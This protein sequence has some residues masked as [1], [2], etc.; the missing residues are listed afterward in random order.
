M[1][2]QLAKSL[3]ARR[4]V[5]LVQKPDYASIY[6]QLGVDSAV[7]PRLICADRILSFIRSES[8]STIATIEEGKAEVL[9]LE[10]GAGS[11]LIGKAL[12]DAA[13]PRGCVVAA[14]TRDDDGAVIPRGH[15][16][17]RAQDQLVL[18]VLHDVVDTVLELVGIERE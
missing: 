4:T 5:A 18:F 3:S 12:K 15:D 6:E 7:S 13:F 1:S 2:C 14:I 16:E 11:A 17:I 9:E 8:V 10:I